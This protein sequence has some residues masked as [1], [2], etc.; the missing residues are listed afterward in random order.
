MRLQFTSSALTISAVFHFFLC[1]LVKKC[2]SVLIGQCRWNI[3][4]PLYVS[5]LIS[6]GRW[7][8]SPVASASMNIIYSS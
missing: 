6:Y 7:L 1:V 8:I 4:S 2:N 5:Y 3:G